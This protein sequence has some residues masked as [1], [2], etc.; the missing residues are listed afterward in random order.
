MNGV[1]GTPCLLLRNV[2][3]FLMGYCQES[4]GNGVFSCPS[5][6]YFRCGEQA[7]SKL[8]VLALAFYSETLTNGA[9]FGVL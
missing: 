1:V 3:V 5:S 6:P 2:F 4:K 9:N 7:P 8:W